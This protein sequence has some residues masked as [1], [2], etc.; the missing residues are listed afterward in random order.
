MLKRGPL[1]G[2]KSLADRSVLNT[3]TVKDKFKSSPKSFKDYLVS[4]DLA[5]PI[6]R[7]KLA[8][9]LK[10][11]VDKACVELFK[12]DPRKHLGASII[13]HDCSAYLWNTFRHLKQEAFDGRMLRLFNRGHLEESRFV[14]WLQ[15]VGFE[16]EE[17]DPATGKQFKIS[18]VNGHFGGSTDG[19]VKLP[20]IYQFTDWLITEFKTHG[21]KS[22]VNLKD[23]GVRKSK[24]MHFKQMSSYGRVYGYRYGLYCAVNKDTDELHFEIA[25]LDWSLA[26]DLFR[27]ADAII[28]SRTQPQK[29][30]QVATYRDCTYCHFKSICF[31]GDEPNKNCRSCEHAVPTE[32]ATW[33][34]MLVNQVIPDEVVKEGCSSWRRII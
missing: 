30:A 6:E 31:Y 32:N 16:V 25:E 21:N 3:T 19:R 14:K 33:T 9:Q 10:M 27:K 13:G 7:G 17:F 12:D 18:G 26:D 4:I 23:E 1:N 34:C 22:F 24:P 28:N 8:V 15:A 5:D 2:R 29:I 20:P 11:D